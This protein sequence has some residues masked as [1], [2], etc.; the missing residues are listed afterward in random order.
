MSP[1]NKRN[2]PRLFPCANKIKRPFH[3]SHCAYISS[4]PKSR[5]FGLP[6]ISLFPS[7]INSSLVVCAYANFLISS[8]SLHSPQSLSRAKKNIA[9]CLSSHSTS[10]LALVIITLQ[11][12]PSSSRSRR[13]WCD[14]WISGGDSSGRDFRCG[15]G[16][17]RGGGVE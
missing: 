11:S 3:P 4:Y 10:T 17:W 1:K 13:G 6:S 8:L 16:D 7:Q 9:V 15:G 14:G 12:T 2:V 5:N